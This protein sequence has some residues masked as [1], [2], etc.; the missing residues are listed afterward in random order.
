MDAQHH[1]ALRD[2]IQQLGDFAALQLDQVQ[3]AIEDSEPLAAL[4][5][6][7]HASVPSQQQQ[8]L[9]LFSRYSEP[10]IGEWCQCF[11]SGIARTLLS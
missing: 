7:T 9:R 1:S 3:G 8:I 6:S 11:R 2:K 4:R 5:R 10:L